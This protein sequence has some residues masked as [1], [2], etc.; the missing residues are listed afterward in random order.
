MVLG[1]C[2]VWRVGLARV[3]SWLS[4]WPGPHFITGEVLMIVC[5]RRH[6]VRCRTTQEFTFNGAAELQTSNQRDQRTEKA[7]QGYYVLL[8]DVSS[9][10]AGP[11]KPDPVSQFLQAVN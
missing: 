2:L 11:I 7:Y 6:A 8:A 10:L 5:C 4:W 9:W 1:G 3:G